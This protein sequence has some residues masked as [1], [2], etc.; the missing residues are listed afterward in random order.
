MGAYVV[1]EANLPWWNT[2][3]G[4]SLDSAAETNPV[5][6]TWSPPGRRECSVQSR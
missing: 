1:A 3:G 2:S 6:I 4:A 5:K